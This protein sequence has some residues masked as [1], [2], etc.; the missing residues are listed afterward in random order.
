[1]I[2]KPVTPDLERYPAQIRSLL[3]DAR[4]YNSS[5]S[6]QAQVIFIEK[7]RGYFVKSAP[8]G[9]LEREA[10]MTQYFHGKGLSAEVISYI[11]DECDWLV[12]TKI[13]GDD[14]TAAKYCEQPERMVDILAEQLS[15]LHGL[16][17]VDCPVPDHTARYLARARK[18]RLAGVFEKDLFTTDWGYTD[19]DEAWAV[20]EEKSHL[21]RMDTLVHGDYC[22]PNIILDDWRFG[23]FIDLDNAGIGDRHVD[24]FWATWTLFYNL[25]TNRYRQRFIEAYGRDKVDED[26]LRLIAAIEQFGG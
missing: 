11:S 20:V 9:T 18:G 23:G 15:L 2:L 24:V 5:C 7:D 13:P 12:T 6:E 3:C 1:M 26:M 17:Y 4:V 10:H 25:K 16:D 14:C 19:A 8:K 21:L 22:L